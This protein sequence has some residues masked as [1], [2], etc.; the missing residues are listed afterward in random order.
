[1]ALHIL[2]SEERGL[3]ENKV[4]KGNTLFSNG[5]PSSLRPHSFGAVY[6]FNDDVLYPGSYLGMHPH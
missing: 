1:M 5:I 3:T 2:K 4:F 6:V